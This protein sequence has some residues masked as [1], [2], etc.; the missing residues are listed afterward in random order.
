MKNQNEFQISEILIVNETNEIFI[1]GNIVR[2]QLSYR[3]E[4]HINSTQLNQVINQL[5]FNNPETSVSEIFVSNSSFS[6]ESI[7][8]L[9]A[10]NLKNTVINL[11]KLSQFGEILQMRA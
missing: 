10:D 8:F 3:S 1:S 6:G 7:Y 2:E 5:Q 11:S 4:M 9:N